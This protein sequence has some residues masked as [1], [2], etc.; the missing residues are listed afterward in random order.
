MIDK[1]EEKKRKFEEHCPNNMDF[2]K[3]SGSCSYR[4]LLSIISKKHTLDV[5]RVI[6]QHS[7]AR[8]NV[9]VK[10]VGGSP[11]TITDR[12]NELCCE[13]ILERKPYAE[14]PPRVEYSLTKKGEDLEPLM[15][16]IKEWSDKW[17]GY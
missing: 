9:I 5:L 12:L 2:F 7:T 13:G 4:K 10:E 8:F 16:R 6:M 3:C 17:D 14:I 11:K 1:N 15:E